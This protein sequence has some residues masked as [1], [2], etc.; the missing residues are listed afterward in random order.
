MLVV[1]PHFPVGKP[2]RLAAKSRIV[3][4][5]ELQ[6]VRSVRLPIVDQPPRR[7]R[8]RILPDANLGAMKENPLPRLARTKI[9][10]KLKAVL[11]HTFPAKPLKNPLLL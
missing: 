10:L 9:E 3:A 2:A 11:H 6:R 8:L 1:F 5:I 7:R 4:A